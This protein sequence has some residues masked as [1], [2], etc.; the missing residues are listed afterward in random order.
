MN[1][2]D[3][4]ANLQAECAVPASVEPV[5][6]TPARAE[7]LSLTSLRGL[8]AAWVV[9]YHFWNETLKL[10]PDLESFSPIAQVGNMAVPAFFMLSG[11]VLSYNYA[12]R[13]KQLSW[14]A[15]RQFLW[16][17]LA[18]VYPVHLFTLLI[19][20][21]MVLVSGRLGYQLTDSGYSTRD[22][23]LNLFLLQTWVPEYQ[24]N[25]NYPAW[26]ISSEW[27]A[28][29]LFPLMATAAM[30]WV[31]T[32]A[33]AVAC[34]LLFLLGS[35]AFTLFCRPW[36]FYEL[37]LVVPTFLAG[38]VLYWVFQNAVATGSLGARRTIPECLVLAILAVCFI[39]DWHSQI[40]A[41]L[42]LLYLLIAFLVWLRERCSV[43]WTCKPAVFLGEVSYSLY[44]THTL[45]Q[46][47]LIR[48]LPAARFEERGWAVRLGIILVY[49]VTIAAGCLATYFLVERPCRRLFKK[50][51]ASKPTP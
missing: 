23:I 34:A 47:I 12:E 20:L 4:S 6:T 51:L 32:R 5:S 33:V 41:L 24:L 18:R 7:I 43:L 46:K 44:M 17:R 16:L 13:F 29:L 25:W 27:F 21:A 30:R 2:T 3:N 28:Y 39:P 42:V 22:F 10:F 19:V 45:A 31:K 11:Y 48:L 1:N 40:G 26:S 8:L 35:V 14:K 36:P 50:V 9:L 37:L 38:A 15:V 49:I